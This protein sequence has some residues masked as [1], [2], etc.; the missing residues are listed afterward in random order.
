[1]PNDK[2]LPHGGI[3]DIQAGSTADIWVAQDSPRVFGF[4]A[5]ATD[6]PTSAFC[7][8]AEEQIQRTQTAFAGI[9]WEVP[10]LLEAMAKAD[11]L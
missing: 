6:D 3:V 5:F 8:N 9:G 11:E 10:H 4:P 1:M 7:R 2:G